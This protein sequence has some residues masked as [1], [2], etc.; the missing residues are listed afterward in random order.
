[1]NMAIQENN[2]EC[3]GCGACESIC[4]K[5]AITLVE[6]TETFLYPKINSNLCVDCGLCE[7]ACPLNYDS[8]SSPEM[9]QSFVGTYNSDDVIYNSSSG[10][11]FTALYEIYISR[12]FK[13]YGVQYDEHLKVVH[14]VATTIEECEKFRKSKYIQSYYDGYYEK[15]V[16]D[17][18][19]GQNVLFSGVSCQCA[20]LS[21]YLKTKKVDTANLI[22]VN[23]LCHGV[24]SQKMFDDYIKE[25]EKEE[26][27]LVYKYR[28]KNKQAF[29]DR[30]NSRTAWVEFRNGHKYIRTVEDDAFL[31]GYYKRLFYRPSCAVCHFARK[32]RLSDFTIAD[33]WNIE[34]IKPNYNPLAGTSLILFNTEKAKIVLEDIK[35]KM[36]LE[37]V[38]NEWSLSSQRLFRA[39]TDMHKNRDKF[40]EQ[41]PKR[42]FKKAVF[43]CTKP[44]LKVRLSRFIPT[45][46][47]NKMKKS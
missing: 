32:D 29:K 6:D 9:I 10:G 40:F 7:K 17:L 27:A 24:P 34:K 33:A 3:C 31:R 16:T 41:W 13:V 39:P 25:E 12:G 5:H 8:F 28:F 35:S 43:M 11:A 23:I 46:V 36:I 38:P 21:A 42:G 47:R 14:G 20:A 26:E 2:K 44:S 22:L 45:C 19:D 15:I 18:K 30:V 1:M 37:E 4:P